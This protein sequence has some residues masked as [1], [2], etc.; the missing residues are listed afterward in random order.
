MKTVPIS[1]RPNKVAAEEFAAP[2]GPDRSF[3]AFIGSLPDV[4]VARDFR[5]VVDAI[6]KAARAHKGIV[7]MLGG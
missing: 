4:L 5:L 6:V 1:R 2:P 7:V 3:D